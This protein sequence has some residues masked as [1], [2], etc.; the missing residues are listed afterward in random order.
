MLEQDVGLE[1]VDAGGVGGHHRD[2]LHQQAGG[3]TQL[4]EFPVHRHLGADHDVGPH[5]LGDIDGEVVPRAAVGQDHVLGAD[6][7]EIERDG[8]RGTHGV[9]QLAGRPVLLAHGVHVRR[10]AE[11]GNGQV[12]ESEGILIADGDGAQGV[13]DVVAE[14][15]AVGQAHAH[16][17]HDFGGDVGGTGLDIVHRLFQVHLAAEP[18]NRVFLL[19]MERNGQGEPFVVL[20]AP[21]ALVRIRHFVGHHDGPVDAPNEGV[22]I[23]RII[24]EGIQAGHQAAHAGAAHQVH[25][26]AQLLHVFEHADMGHAAGAASAEDDGDGGPMLA[27]GVHP[28]PDPGDGGGIRLGIHAGHD[29]P[30]PVLGKR[31]D[32]HKRGQDGYEKAFHR[33][34]KGFRM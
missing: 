30:V 10:H 13:S 29:Q 4:G 19:I 3:G 24:A 27:D 22:Q 34:Q 12:F 32:G 15:V 16:L 28:G 20:P 17:G 9:H 25:G 6:R 1:P 31:A 33:L 7:P 8:H 2:V 26:N 23:L 11:E 5:R 18:G 14:Q 21:V